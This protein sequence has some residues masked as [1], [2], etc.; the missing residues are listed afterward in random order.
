MLY[1]LIR[2]ILYRFQPDT[3][4]P[5]V[6][7]GS[8]LV[9]RTPILGR[10]LRR[11][12][13]VDDAALR[14]TV[15]GVTYPNPV[16]LSAGFDKDGQNLHFAETFGFGFEEVGSITGR[17]YQGNPKPWARRMVRNES[18][19]V[20]YGLKSQGV[21]RVAQR[22]ERTHVA[23]PYGVSVAKSNL[24]DC[25]GDVAIAD[26]VKV[27]VRTKDL[28]RYATINLSCPN[29]TDG[30]PFSEPETLEPLLKALTEAREQH[31]IRK[32][33]YLKINPDIQR[34]KLDR[35]IDLVQH[36]RLQGLVIG[37]L[38]KDKA[39][40]H[41]LLDYPDDH[42]LNWPGGISGKPVRNL[43]TEA[44][45]YVYSKTHGKMTIIGTGG[46]FTG[47]HAY[48]KIRAGASL[49]Q[50]ITGFIFGGPTTIRNINKRLLKLLRRDGFTNVSQAVGTDHKK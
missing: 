40:A 12:F 39:R 45:R 14:T 3:I 6:A 34:E 22:L 35:I 32:P 48:E 13:R 21:E 24:P 23:M 47:D 5:I 30:T 36:Y 44:I 42:D 4:H 31:G 26:Y 38:I 33:T 49:V 10:V 11:Y 28:G 43:S 17:E 1:R 50:L 18:L 46:I 16:G 41:A 2:P 29:T 7:G 8:E 25:C 20:N 9:A 37:N 27:Y 19:V 15:D